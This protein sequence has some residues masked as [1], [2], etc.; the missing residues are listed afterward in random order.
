MSIWIKHDWDTQQNDC[1]Q[2]NIEDKIA[3][4]KQLKQG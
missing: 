3:L 4:I 1:V 2:S